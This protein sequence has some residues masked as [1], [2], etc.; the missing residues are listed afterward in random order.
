M[1]GQWKRRKGK[2]VGHRGK[3]MNDELVAIAGKYKEIIQCG[4][5]KNMSEYTN[6]SGSDADAI[7]LGWQ[8]TLSGE[9][10]ALYNI[11]ATGHP[12][13]GSTVAE[14]GLR[15]LNLQVSGAPLLH[16]CVRKF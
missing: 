1:E 9:I 6:Q 11:T 15:K 12:L 13:L 2:A 8:E 14:K 5:K 7:F 3:M 16:G 10:I 4:R